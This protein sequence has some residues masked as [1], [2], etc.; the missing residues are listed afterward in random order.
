MIERYRC[1]I[2]WEL[3]RH[4]IPALMLAFV[5]GLAFGYAWA[6]TAYQFVR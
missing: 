2:R 6:K 1:P 3:A 5:M 4:V